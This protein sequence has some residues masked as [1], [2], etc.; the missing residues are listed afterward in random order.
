MEKITPS[1]V[2]CLCAALPRSTS[3]LTAPDCFLVVGGSPDRRGAV[4]KGACAWPALECLLN[5]LADQKLQGAEWRGDEGASA[6]KTSPGR[7]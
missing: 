7:A 6:A 4:S 1:F 3:Q 2:A 5:S